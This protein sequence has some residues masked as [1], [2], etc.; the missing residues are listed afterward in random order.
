M[1]L[2]I[3]RRTRTGSEDNALASRG[4]PGPSDMA[5]WSSP[6][7]KLPMARTMFTDES[8]SVRRR[9]ARARVVRVGAIARP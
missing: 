8:K 7:R 1:T 3:A 4:E 2:Y 6:W 9:A 5:R